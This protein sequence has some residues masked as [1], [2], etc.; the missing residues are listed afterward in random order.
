[1]DLHVADHP[2]IAHK[3]TVLRDQT[4]DSARFRTLTDELV[5]LLS[6]EAI[7]SVSNA[8]SRLRLSKIKVTSALF[9]GLRY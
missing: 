7:S 6:Y 4:T 8:N 2:L 3:L 5:M 9:N 1:M